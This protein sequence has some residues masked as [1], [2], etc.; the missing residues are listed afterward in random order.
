MES[1]S[2]DGE[3]EMDLRLLN[4]SFKHIPA[5]Y[6]KKGHR[7]FVHT[8]AQH[9]CLRPNK[10][11]GCGLYFGRLAGPATYSILH[12][13][14][15]NKNIGDIT[16]DHKRAPPTL[17]KS[18]ATSICLLYKVRLIYLFPFTTQFLT[19]KCL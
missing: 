18:I 9:L 12:S 17:N 11:M 10:N 13:D 1:K 16:Y 5:F 6:S 4:M 19:D 15:F 3:S 8:M 7:I 14:L 2:N